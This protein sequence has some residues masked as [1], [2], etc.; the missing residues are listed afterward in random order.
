M[1]ENIAW[2]VNP[3]EERPDPPT[4][5]DG[6]QM[7]P[8][9]EFNLDLLPD[10]LAEDDRLRRQEEKNAERRAQGLPEKEYA[11]SKRLILC[12]EMSFMSSRYGWRDGESATTPA[13]IHVTHHQLTP[14]KEAHYEALNEAAD[15]VTIT[16][17]RKRYDTEHRLIDQEVVQFE[18]GPWP[19]DLR[20]Q[21]ERKHYAAAEFDI[22]LP[23]LFNLIEGK[24][25]EVPIPKE[26]QEDLAR[27]IAQVTGGEA[28][29]DDYHAA[30]G[31]ADI[32]YLVQHTLEMAEAGDDPHL[33]AEERQR[34]DLQRMD[35]MREL[36]A[37]F[38]PPK[39]PPVK[40]GQ[41]MTGAQK[42]ARWLET[43]E[44]RAARTAAARAKAEAA[45]R[46]KA[47]AA[48]KATVKA[49]GDAERA[50]Q[51]LPGWASPPIKP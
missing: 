9:E 23:R 11:P 3:E 22:L 26:A 29:Q 12:G 49:L 50:K 32:P 5:E 8:P 41:R 10:V 19:Q 40:R 39:K 33:P 21:L 24:W 35:K 20:E 31:R 47:L 25:E 16:S 45:A 2:D 13:L 37:R 28:I 1:P 36:M 30:V 42:I 18:V 43:A 27:A 14:E 46:A 17:K 48:A 6:E 38:P 34:R 7:D 4:N 15:R 51:V 44:D